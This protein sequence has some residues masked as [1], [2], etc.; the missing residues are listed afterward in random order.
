MRQA[1]PISVRP[2]FEF[3]PKGFANFS[4]ELERS[5][6]PGNKRTKHIQN[7]ERVRGERNPFRVERLFQ[8][9]FPELSLR[10]NSGLKLANAFG[11]IS[12]VEI[13]ERVGANL[14]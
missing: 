4:P 8:T 2:Q 11:V 14:S 5:D 10:S 9:R 3:T 1:G 13:C 12:R 6:N 7:P